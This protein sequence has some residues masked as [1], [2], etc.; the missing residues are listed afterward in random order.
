MIAVNR[1]LKQSFT[2]LEWIHNNTTDSIEIAIQV[3]K[4]LLLYKYININNIIAGLNQLLQKK[5]LRNIIIE[6]SK[7]INKYLFIKKL[8][9]NNIKNN[10]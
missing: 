6:Y 5:K 7:K 1:Y 8:I 9:N 4:W 2:K 3:N 10:T